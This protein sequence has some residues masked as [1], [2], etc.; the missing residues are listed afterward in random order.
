MKKYFLFD[1]E[2]ITGWNYWMRI[3]IGTLT[4]VLFGIGLW[5]LAATGY[6]RAGTFNW[7]KELRVLS[8]IFIPFNG[9]INILSRDSYYQDLPFSFLDV[10]VLVGAIF[11]L[12]LLFKNGNKQRIH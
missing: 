10:I 9:V 11:H 2:P 5:V 8:A 12:V 3:L 6:K 1:N 7:N 4:I